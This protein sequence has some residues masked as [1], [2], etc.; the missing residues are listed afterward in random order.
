MAEQQ[1]ALLELP[2]QE[3]LHYVKQVLLLTAT[4]FFQLLFA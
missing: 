2:E 3:C 4:T 1:E